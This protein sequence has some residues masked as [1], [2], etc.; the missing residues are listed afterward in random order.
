MASSSCGK[1]FFFSKSSFDQYSAKK[2]F[3]ESLDERIADITKY[4]S[5]EPVEQNDAK[6]PEPVCAASHCSDTHELPKTKETRKWNPAESA[7]KSALHEKKGGLPPEKKVFSPPEKKGVTKASDQDA[8]SWKQHRLKIT[9]RPDLDKPGSRQTRPDMNV[10]SETPFKYSYLAP[11]KN[12]R[13][14]YPRESS[15]THEEHKRYLELFTHFVAYVPSN[16]TP[17]EIKDILIFKV[18]MNL[19]LLLVSIILH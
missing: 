2:S 7:P 12:P 14:P 6:F 15:L 13:I 3:E 11:L 18:S 10:I 1:N 9:T 4:K 19:F 5:N 17:A 16:P 8:V